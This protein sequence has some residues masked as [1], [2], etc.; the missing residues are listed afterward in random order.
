MGIYE[1]L[2]ILD[3]KNLGNH[4]T[5]LNPEAGNYPITTNP[6]EISVSIRSGMICWDMFSYYEHRY[7]ERG[8]RFARS[9]AVWLVSVSEL[10]E[11]IATEQV[12]WLAR[13]LAIRGMPTYT[14]EVQMRLHYKL[15][16]EKLPEYEVRY[17]KFLK[18]A[19]ELKAIRNKFI[20]DS[21][22][23][24]SNELFAKNLDLMSL[25]YS[26][27]VLPVKNTGLLIASS[28]ADAG[29]NIPDAVASLKNWLTD[30]SRFPAGWIDAI[31]KTYSDLEHKMG[32]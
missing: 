22:F 26:S 31:R 23:E 19:D 12:K 17:R 2:T 5:S 14:M 25:S 16:S 7:G 28:L 10:P 15:L 9:D 6:L 4:I 27:D 11:Q 30:D 1:S 18:A 24:K 29:N 3:Q 13:Y 32:K 21:L 20:D 8:R